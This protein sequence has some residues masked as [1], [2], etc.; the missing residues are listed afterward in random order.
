MTAKVHSVRWVRGLYI[1]LGFLNVIL[2]IIGA[3]LPVM[4]TTPFILLGAYFFARG[5]DRWHNWLLAHKIFGPLIIAFR[6]EKR[7][8][9]KIKFLVTGMICVTVTSTW[10]LIHPP[11]FGLIGMIAVCAGVIIYIWTFKN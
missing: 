6:D 3:F 2:G 5:S 9:L 11:L 7:I 1:A 8:P 4:P 10:L